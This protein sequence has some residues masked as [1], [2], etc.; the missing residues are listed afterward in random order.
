MEKNTRRDFMK[1]L[2]ISL[3]AAG[4]LGSTSILSSCNRVEKV[5]GDKIQKNW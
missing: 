2:G 4:V 5:E 3:G 1:K